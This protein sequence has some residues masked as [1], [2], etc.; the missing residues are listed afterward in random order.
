MLCLRTPYMRFFQP[1]ISLACV[2]VLI[3][4]PAGAQS[5]ATSGSERPSFFTKITDPAAF[6]LPHGAQSYGGT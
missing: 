2:F 6:N 4:P 3:V 1:A 5:A